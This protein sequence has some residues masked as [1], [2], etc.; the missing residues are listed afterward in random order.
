M[1]DSTKFFN[2]FVKAFAGWE[3]QKPEQITK[4]A[5]CGMR[6][7]RARDKHILNPGKL[8]KPGIKI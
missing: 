5:F 4:I 8:L 7:F 3:A 6:F 2:D 1:R